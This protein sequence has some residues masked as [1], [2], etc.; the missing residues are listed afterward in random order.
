MWK[1]T[2]CLKIWTH[3]YQNG[4]QP[5]YHYSTRIFVKDLV[6]DLIW[7]VQK[8]F[9]G[10]QFWKTSAKLV[11]SPLRKLQSPNLGSSHITDP[12]QS[13]GTPSIVTQQLLCSSSA[14]TCSLLESDF[15][16]FMLLFCSHSEVAVAQ[17]S[18]G[19]QLAVTNYKGVS[20]ANTSC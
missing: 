16:I 6:W 19:S 13:F 9:K 1:E 14:I 2:R 5:C 15:I 4:R 20:I 3:S 11:L 10:N 18:H 8:H 12:E 7:W 17:Q